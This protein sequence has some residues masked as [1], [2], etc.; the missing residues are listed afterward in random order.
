MSLITYLTRIHFADRVLED[1]LE[2]ELAHLGSSRLLIVTD[3]SA[4]ADR[5]RLAAVLPEPVQLMEVAGDEALESDCLAAA[6]RFAAG[7][8]DGVIGFG[9]SAAIDVA[10]LVAL[11]RGDAALLGSQLDT[12]AGTRTGLAR[13]VPMIAVPTTAGSG[14]GVSRSI[15]ILRSNGRR[16]SL[17][18]PR[19]IPAA[20]LCDP[21]LGVEEG[22][23]ATAAAG[24][25]A[26]THCFE[27]YLGTAWNP[28]ADGIALEGLRRA[29]L[30]IERAVA[31][32]ADIE[33]RRELL[34]AALNGALAEEKGLGGVH[35]LTHALEEARAG[36]PRHGSLHAALLPQVLE[37]NAPAVGDRY[38]SISEA[39]RLAPGSDL[40]TA[41]AKLGARLGL[42]DRL[43]GLGLEAPALGRVALRAEADAANRTNPRLAD[44]R[45]YRAMLE[46]A[47]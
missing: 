14:A 22:A 37:F 38:R 9:G 20:A 41:I 17:A 34:A 44:A 27:T 5:D 12:G 45:D 39:M 31:D 10:K 28:P 21:T 4:Q 43:G 32:G 35:A 8:C 46:A 16:V 13:P 30:H 25:D 47:L 7:R 18:G 2:A 40:P 19:L 11:V 6:R 23:D 29:A 3:R 1:A 15:G 36:P 42:P 33:A 24:M 26:L